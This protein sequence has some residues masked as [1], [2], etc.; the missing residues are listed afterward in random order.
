MGAAYSLVVLGDL[1]AAQRHAQHAVSRYEAQGT[2][3]VDLTFARL[4]LAKAQP[5]PAAAAEIG[6]A[7]I[8]AYLAQ[9]RRSQLIVVAARQLDARLPDSVPEVEDFRER[10]HALEAST[11]HVVP[12]V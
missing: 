8:E 1:P 5:D 2:S 4:G 9:H 6:T 3:S 12:G 7:A 10:L 11:R